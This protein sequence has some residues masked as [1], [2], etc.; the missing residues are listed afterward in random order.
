M[1]IK[2]RCPHCQQLLGISTTKSGTIV[3]CPACGR[4]VNVPAEGGVATRT[5]PT[6]RSSDNPGL[7]DALQELSTLG[8]Q[9]I[10]VGVVPEIWKPVPRARKSPVAKAPSTQSDPNSSPD[11]D[12]IRIVPLVNVHATPAVKSPEPVLPELAD[13]Q[14]I[15]DSAPLILADPR[16]TDDLAMDS[17]SGQPPASPHNLALPLQELADVS[18]SVQS[19]ETQ[20]QSAATQKTAAT[21]FS[22]W[23][24]MWTL[25]AFAIGLFLGTFWNSNSPDGITNPA[26]RNAAA[27]AVVIPAP[28]VGERQLKGVVRYVNDAGK[29][30]PDSGAVVLLLPI[31]N[32]TRLRLD[33]RP[34]REPPDSK[35]RQAIEVA[36][37][38]LGGSVHQVDDS[39]N[40]AANVP[41]DAA[42]MMITI[43][44]HRSR[45]ESQPV[46]AAVLESLDRWFQSPLH[47]VGRLS[48]KKSVV[49]ADTGNDNTNS[50]ETEFSQ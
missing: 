47:I 22:S 23:P 48:V 36:L 12:T 6:L 30:L 10:D 4:S 45:T 17:N 11:R 13:F 44:R 7:Q 29:S 33:A 27:P 9:N 20:L 39:G 1:A 38:I 34:L 21:L 42:L 28:E 16:E 46:P 49:S 43:S 5:E 19:Q 3:D 15:E 24:L 8:A 32:P 41:S 50:M 35:A 40:W 37:K 26:P 25:P 31:E 14:P 2:F 18:Y